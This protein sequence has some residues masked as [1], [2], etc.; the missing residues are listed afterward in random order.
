[1]CDAVDSMPFTYTR[2]FYGVWADYWVAQAERVP[3]ILG[4]KH[5][6]NYGIVVAVPL[7]PPE[8]EG[9]IKWM[10]KHP[11]WSVEPEGASLLDEIRFVGHW[12]A[13]SISR[14]KPRSP[15]TAPTLRDERR[16]VVP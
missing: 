16:R 2:A 12:S 14:K 3:P 5:S 8:V 10:R 15:L 11:E 7:G 1:M 4:F 9:F 6:L 13:I